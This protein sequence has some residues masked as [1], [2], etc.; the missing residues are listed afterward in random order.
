MSCRRA[1][2]SAICDCRGQRCQAVHH[3]GR[4]MVQPLRHMLDELVWQIAGLIMRIGL[5]ASNARNRFAASRPLA[6]L[7]QLP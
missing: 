2:G 1:N 6:L 5:G 7:D 4:V 3:L